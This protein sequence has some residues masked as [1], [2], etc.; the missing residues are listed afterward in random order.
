MRAEAYRHYEEISVP[1]VDVWESSDRI[2]KKLDDLREDIR[3]VDRKIGEIHD[4]L[5]GHA[6]QAKDV[7]S[8]LRQLDESGP[9]QAYVDEVRRGG[10]YVRARY[11][12]L[13]SRAAPRTELRPARKSR[14]FQP[15]IF[16][17]IQRGPTAQSHDGPEERFDDVAGAVD[18][19]G[20]SAVIQGEPGAGKT[21]ALWRLMA[22]DADAAVQSAS[23][24]LP[25]L[26]SLGS[27]DGRSD[28]L[29]FVRSQ[30]AEAVIEVE[31][32][33]FVP[34]PAHRRLAR[35]LEDELAH[36]R[37]TLFFDGL[38]E[39]PRDC[40]ASAVERLTAFRASQPGNRFVF[41]CREADYL[42][43]LPL[44]EI[45]IEPL[46]DEGIGAFARSYLD[47]DAE[48]FLDSISA[49]DRTIWEMGRNPYMLQLV[50]SLF[51]EQGTLPAN[52]AALF[53]EFLLWLLRRERLRQNDGCE[54]TRIPADDRMQAAL[55][56]RV[57]ARWPT[58]AE[59]N[60]HPERF[61]LMALT[62]AHRRAFLIQAGLACLTLARLAYRVTASAEHGTTIS[63][64]V[65]NEA[66]SHPLSMDE[67]EPASVEPVRL[68]HLA[69]SASLVQRKPDGIRFSH[70]LLQEYFAAVHLQALGPGHP[71]IFE[72]VGFEAWDQV[73]LLLSG[74]HGHATPLVEHLIL[75]DP[76]F[77]ARCCGV[78]PDTVSEDVSNRLIARLGACAVDVYG[79]WR[80][81]ALTALA[82]SR[83]PS[84][85]PVL[86]DLLDDTTL[87]ERLTLR[88]IGQLGRPE[89]FDVLNRCLQ[90]D[91]PGLRR[92]AAARALNILGGTQA[93]NAI[94]ARL[95]Q[96][97]ESLRESAR[98]QTP[99]SS[100]RW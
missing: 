32:D 53:G 30:L 89:G 52:R 25:V 95:E 46:D 75:L 37:L 55:L 4:H 44:S 36:G 33:Q 68:L 6:K 7:K 27:Y 51:E 43:K 86:A 76:F 85:L 50:V 61:G 84:A 92:V 42:H 58:V 82:D 23:A 73:M 88:A 47:D 21:T 63:L 97:D 13:H 87:D 22:A 39:V 38:N 69:A 74:L 41:T 12:P 93:V 15:K 31:E 16:R 1:T 9:R 34:L 99:T 3:K 35:E 20:G 90:G 40:Q 71:E 80:S 98:R 62:D 10:D 45:T 59:W 49:G 2:G 100:V 64:D 66:L 19:C 57:M 24:P 48:R 56:I 60:E 29:G 28:V 67:A 18:R 8:I 91:Q 70:Q 5:L 14:T 17:V 79:P 78:A 77:A 83:L 26:A 96:G 81:E 72:R 54:V 94:V 65:A 11:V